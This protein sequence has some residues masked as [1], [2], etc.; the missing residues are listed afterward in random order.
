MYMYVDL[1]GTARRAKVVV[2]TWLV[3]RRIKEG[4]DGQ[5]E[6]ARTNAS[7]NKSE[8]EGAEERRRS[9]RRRRRRR[10][11]KKT[12][13]KIEKS[14]FQEEKKREKKKKKNLT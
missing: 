2:S 9:G 7:D 1:P 13:T 14:D 6:V 8:S 5:T 10:T 3:R 12:K 11:A 4:E